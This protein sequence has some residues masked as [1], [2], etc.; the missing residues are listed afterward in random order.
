MRQDP[1]HPIAKQRK[2]PRGLQNVDRLKAISY[3]SQIEDKN[4]LQAPSLP[5]PPI[6]SQDSWKHRG[7]KTTRETKHI[8]KIP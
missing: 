1:G 6:R 4:I 3:Y 7:R 5:T 8:H 2:S